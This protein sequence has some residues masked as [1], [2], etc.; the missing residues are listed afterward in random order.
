M[1]SENWFKII[2]DEDEEVTDFQKNKILKVHIKKYFH[3]YE[4]VLL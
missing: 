1:L 4:P 2:W 3:H